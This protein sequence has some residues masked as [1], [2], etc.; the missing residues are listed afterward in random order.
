MNET[1]FNAR[2]FRESCN[3]TRFLKEQNTFASSPAKKFKK[4]F[5][6]D[7]FVDT[8]HVKLVLIRFILSYPKIM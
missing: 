2:L 4:I 6:D 1:L 8:R 3:R 7:R 5:Y